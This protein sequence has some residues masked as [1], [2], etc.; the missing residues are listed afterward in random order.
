[1]GTM[2]CFKTLSAIGARDYVLKGI[3]YQPPPY[4][5]KIR[6]LFRFNLSNY[7]VAYEVHELEDGTMQTAPEN[8]QKKYRKQKRKY[9]CGCL[10]TILIVKLFL[11]TEI[12]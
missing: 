8:S 6:S 2:C 3:A 4:K 11:E 1:M 12:I 5:S 9:V 10:D 7:C